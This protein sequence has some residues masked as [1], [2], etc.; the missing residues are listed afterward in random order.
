[1]GKFEKQE[2]FGNKNVFIFSTKKK[3]LNDRT[4]KDAIRLFIICNNILGSVVEE[5]YRN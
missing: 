1:M 3:K 2:S 4:W 5:V